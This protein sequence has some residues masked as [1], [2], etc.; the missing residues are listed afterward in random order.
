MMKTKR[1]YAPP[2]IDIGGNDPDHPSNFV[3]TIC[4]TNAVTAPERIYLN[5]VD[6]SCICA[7][8]AVRV[9]KI[10]SLLDGGE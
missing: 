3:C 8:C 5:L 10:A 9:Q 7:D 1:D 2:F 6:G 4:Q